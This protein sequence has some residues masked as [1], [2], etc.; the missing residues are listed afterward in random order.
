MF[1]KLRPYL[2]KSLLVEQS[3]FGTSELLAMVPGPAIDGRFF[4]YVT[5]SKPWIEWA[6]ATSYGT[7]MPR[8]SWEAMAEYRIDQPPL[9]DQRRIADFLD[10]QVAILDDLITSRQ[11][12]LHLMH[13]RHASEV[14]RLLNRVK[15]PALP[16]R[17]FLV[18]PPSYG[19][20]KPDG[21]EGADARPLLKIYNISE[22]G[23]LDHVGGLSTIS[24]I[25]DREYQRTKVAKGDVVLSVVGTIGRV[26]VI[27][28]E[29]AGC[30]LSRAIARLEVST[31]Y[32]GRLVRW[33]I[34]SKKFDDFV[35]ITCQGT[36]QSVLN[37]GDLAKFRI[38]ATG[39][40]SEVVSMLEDRHEHQTS[41]TLTLER[42]I[43]LLAERKQ[44]LITAAVTG[45]FDIT[46]A[47]KVPVA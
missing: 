8:T 28:D 47:R 22:S 42:S 23:K 15:G 33:W 41:T 30:N 37:M 7:K 34:Q 27:G 46:T 14:D 31:Q 17:Y 32:D 40:D 44:A 4:K 29:H 5:L 35:R 11:T 6:V 21:Y 16:L 20:L 18:K 2:A 39:A 3:A 1:S 25:Q 45:Q 13:E 26:S 38:R 43:M 12:Q 24:P 10:Q 36:A 19:V 9:E